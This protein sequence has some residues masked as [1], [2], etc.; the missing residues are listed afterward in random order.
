MNLYMEIATQLDINYERAMKQMRRLVDTNASVSDQIGHVRYM[1][2]LSEAR[3]I[4][5]QAAKEVLEI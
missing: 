5:T 2:G 1:Q 3:L 4:V